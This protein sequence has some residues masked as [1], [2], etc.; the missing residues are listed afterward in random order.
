MHIGAPR[1][2]I[3]KAAF[4]CLIQIRSGSIGDAASHSRRLA[5]ASTE[6]AAKCIDQTATRLMQDRG[7]YPII[8]ERR[9]EQA[10]VTMSN[11]LSRRGL[12]QVVL[13][14]GQTTER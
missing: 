11:Q 9:G 5:I 2:R 1:P 4:D 13:E 10:G 12:P 8:G 3:F 14:R 6:G 7:W